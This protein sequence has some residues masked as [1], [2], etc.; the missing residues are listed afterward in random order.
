MLRNDVTR[1]K[2]RLKALFRSRGLIPP[3]REAFRE[4]KHEAWATQLPKELR[5]SAGVLLT[6]LEA[7]ETL[8]PTR[9]NDCARR[10]S[11]TGS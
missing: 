11:S 5:L 1:A 8:G 10:R 6:E 7:L 9:K 3:G 4:Q 2:S